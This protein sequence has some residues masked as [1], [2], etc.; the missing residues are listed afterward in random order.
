[1]KT[2]LASMCVLVA[3]APAAMAVVPSTE[4]FLPS[5]GRGQGSCPGGVCS[6]WRTDVWVLNPSVA[7]SATVQISFLLRNADNSDPATETVTVAPG[8][9]LELADVMQSLF[10]LDGVFGALRLVADQ[11]V[12]VTGRIYDEN[13][14]TSSGTGTAGQFFAAMPADLALS[15]GDATDLIGLAQDG[16]DIWRTNFGFVETTGNPVTVEVGLF[17]GDGTTVASTTYDLAGFGVTQVSIS[18]IGGPPGENLRIRVSVTDGT[19][20]V[21]TFASR[22]DNRTGDPSTVEMVGSAVAAHETG[23]F[24]GVVATPDGL[25]VDGGMELELT[26]EGLVSFAGTAGISCGEFVLTVDFGT[27]PTSPVALDDGGSFSTTLDQAYNDG[28]IIAFNIHWTLTGTLDQ[29]VLVGTLDSVASDG[30][31]G[32]APCDGSAE[33]SWRAGWVESVAR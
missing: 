29:G 6:Q 9:T 14:Q 5:V 10:A 20:R 1:M 23:W 26:A 4:V 18:N 11:E 32:Y 24:S 28:A 33:R 15:S 21:L 2:L 7:G 27:S 31:G 30:V 17:T 13:V 8:Q 25:Y 12:A 19:G 22:I 3:I 16:A